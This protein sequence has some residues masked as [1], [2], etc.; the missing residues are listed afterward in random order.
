MGL[1]LLKKD[2]FLMLIGKDTP[3]LTATLSPNARESRFWT[4]NTVVTELM[5]AIDGSV[6]YVGILVNDRDEL[7]EEIE[8]AM[9]RVVWFSHQNLGTSF[10][11]VVAAVKVLEGA[12][13]TN[14]GLGSNL[15]E[16]GVVECDASIMD[17]ET[18][19]YGA[20]GA[21]PEDMVPQEQ[22]EVEE[23]DEILVPEQIL[24]H[25]DRKVRGKVAR[26]Y[27]VKFKNCSPMD[28]KW[29]EETELRLP[30]SEVSLS[31]AAGL[32]N[33]IEVAAALAEES[34]KGSLS[35][36]RIPPIFLAGDGARAWASA[37]GLKVAASP[38][39]AGKDTWL[40]TERTYCQWQRYKEMLKQADSVILSKTF[41][42]S[43]QCVLSKDVAC[44]L[45]S[46][47][48]DE[49]MDTVGAVCVDSHGNVAVGSSSGGIAMK[50]R[51]RIGVAAT[52]GSGCWASSHEVQGGSVGCCVTGAGEHL[53][54]GLVA[55]ECCTSVSSLQQDPEYAC[56]ETLSKTLQQARNSVPETSGG[57]L[58]VQVNGASA[59]EDCRQLKS[60]EI[61]AAYATPSFGVG[62][63]HSSMK[64]P[65]ATI[66]RRVSGKDMTQISSFSS[67]FR[68]SQEHSSTTGVG[69]SC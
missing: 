63:F 27:L 43:T 51:G 41:V 48:C 23:V 34:R 10:D 32:Q 3:K 59:I 49:V 20:V 47:G 7:I 11:A 25:K 55:Y 64:K 4:D 19:A 17:G 15:T 69:A 46:F 9:G 38:V 26:R 8:A 14:A 53:M 13:I 68:F 33:P 6:L 62:Y 22:L 45:S 40:I 35:C 54:K 67:L 28:A 1:G 12:D 29:M 31:P 2:I 52:Y 50:V 56:K 24:A 21:A 61:V 66:L 16:D 44:Q 58:L 60:L 65:K 18:C 5:I 37:H 36:G 42:K 39:E 57:V 30:R